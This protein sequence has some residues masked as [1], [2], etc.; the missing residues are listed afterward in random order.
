M[1]MVRK[2]WLAGLV[3]LVLVTSLVAGAA[4]SQSAT[5]ARILGGSADTRTDNSWVT[6]V[7]YR[8]SYR[9]GDGFTR[10][11]CTGSL[12]KPRWVLTAA[13]C[14]TNDSG[15][16]VSPSTLEVL[17]G[18]KD[19]NDDPD[20]GPGE[21]INVVQVRR[22]PGYNFRTLRG[23]AALLKLALPSAHV[24]V[25]LAA[26]QPRAGKR[27]YIAG[28]GDTKPRDSGQNAFPTELRSAYIRTIGDRTCARS[29]IHGGTYDRRTMFCAG[30][31]TGRP[32][33][34]Q[35]DS[36]GPI[37]INKGGAR[38]WR[39]IGVTSYG[40]CGRRPP[41]RGVYSRITANPLEG[42]IKRILP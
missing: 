5:H 9:P 21:S 8:E 22:F 31:S 39:L 4:P 38:P 20:T 7:L 2:P 12:V 35:G 34:C 42:W 14:I 28:W 23:D 37:A 25:L 3:A 19:L 40:I 16:K 15:G 32:D 24:P 18:Q 13:H 29:P 41:W 10:Q 1:G 17:I 26:N 30:T 11:F 6:A 36:G 27:A 33:T